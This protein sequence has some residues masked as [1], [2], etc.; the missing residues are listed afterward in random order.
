M[1]YDIQHTCTRAIRDAVVFEIAGINGVPNASLSSSKSD[2][3]GVKQETMSSKRVFLT[4]VVGGI[5]GWGEEE[6][7]MKLRV[8][9]MMHL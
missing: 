4:M 9:I 2:R 3:I 1:L 5:L 8:C 6:V 7:E